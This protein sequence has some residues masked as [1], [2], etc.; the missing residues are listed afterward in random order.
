MYEERFLEQALS[1]IESLRED[2]IE[3]K[4]KLLL[5]EQL[6]KDLKY[7]LKEEKHNEERRIRKVH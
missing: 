4:R 2:N 3:L 6:F 1:E 7:I 5:Y